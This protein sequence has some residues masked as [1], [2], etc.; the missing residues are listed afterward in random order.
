MF[1]RKER[2]DATQRNAAMLVLSRKP[3]EEI[4]IGDDITL[5]VVRIGPNT[6]RIGITAPCGIS[7]VRTE[8]IDQ[9]PQNEGSEQ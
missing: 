3:G 4:L 7:I 5:T 6:V 2:T 9:S 8:I 1:A